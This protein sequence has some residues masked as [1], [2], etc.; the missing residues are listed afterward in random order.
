M[1]ERQHE[2]KEGVNER[3]ILETE[4]AKSIMMAQLC[5]FIQHFSVRGH[6]L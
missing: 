3:R 6:V 5:A 4:K 1:K 2:S